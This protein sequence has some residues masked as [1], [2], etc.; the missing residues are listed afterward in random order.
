MTLIV[1]TLDELFLFLAAGLTK[2]LELGLMKNSEGNFI[3]PVKGEGA[4]SQRIFKGPENLT[5]WE[6]DETKRH[7]LVTCPPI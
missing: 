7:H 6:E 3:F 5:F 1:T 4:L 2:G